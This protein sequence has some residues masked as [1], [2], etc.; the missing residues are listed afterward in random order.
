MKSLVVGT[1]DG[2][3]YIYAIKNLPQP[4][5]ENDLEDLIKQSLIS[6]LETVSVDDEETKE[7]M[8]KH[9][10]ESLQTNEK[11]QEDDLEDDQKNKFDAF[12]AKLDKIKS[13][14]EAILQGKSVHKNKSKSKNGA[15]NEPKDDS[16]S[17][18]N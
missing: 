2:N 12:E 15:Q 6:Q 18:E 13:E 17:D 14:N 5:K 8:E 11:S 3:L 10:L 9:Q 4:T 1:N 16:S 7:M